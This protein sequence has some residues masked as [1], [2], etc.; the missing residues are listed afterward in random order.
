MPLPGAKRMLAD[1]S[2]CDR[3]AEKVRDGRGLA[4]IW[5]IPIR[6]VDGRRRPKTVRGIPV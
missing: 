6:K 1:L 5:E 3:I 2:E 4:V